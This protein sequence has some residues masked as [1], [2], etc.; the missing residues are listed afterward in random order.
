VRS[1]NFIATL[2]DAYP[3]TTEISGTKLIL[4]NIKYHTCYSRGRS[5]FS[6]PQS[7]SSKSGSCADQS[8]RRPCD[9]DESSPRRVP[10]LFLFLAPP[11]SRPPVVMLLGRLRAI[12]P[13]A[14]T[15]TRAGQLQLQRASTERS[16]SGPARRTDTRAGITQSMGRC[17]DA[18]SLH[19]TGRRS[20]VDV[21]PASD[22]L[23]IVPPTAAI[24][25]AAS[26]PLPFAVVGS[27]PAAFYTSKY[28]LRE[29]AH[30]RVDMFERLPVPFGLVRFGVAPDHPDVKAVTNDFAQVANDSRFQYYGN[31]EVGRDVS[32]EELRQHYAGVI[33]AYGAA[34]ERTLSIPGSD[35]KGIHPSRHFVNWYNGHPEHTSAEHDFALEK[36]RTAVIVGQGNV[37]ID[38]ARVLLSPVSRLAN[39]DIST[40]SLAQLASSSVQRCHMIGRRGAVQSAFSI[41]ELREL[42]TSVEGLR[43]V[44]DKEEF[45]QSENETSLREVADSRPKKRKHDLMRQILAGTLPSLVPHST[46]TSTP[47]KDLHLRYFLTPLRFLP[48][49][50]D[51]SRVGAIVLSRTRLE[52]PP[53]KQQAVETGE[54]VVMETELVLTSIGYRSLPVS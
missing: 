46:T 28:L 36:V 38:C 10:K 37:A 5:E 24:A 54:E 4:N 2:M 15:R 29:L 21:P 7:I 1:R 23:P 42:A 43:L 26:P 8:T 40:H 19:S 16:S 27:G 17:E 52:G 48:S 32:V 6:S 18:R 47:P 39:T 31:V 34:S 49:L 30:A 35:L 53:E 20:M 50:N 41:G 45:A 14:S 44:M 12:R 13:P 22:A 33:L 9:A 11:S 51:P 3:F 25:A